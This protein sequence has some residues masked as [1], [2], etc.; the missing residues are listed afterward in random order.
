MQGFKGVVVVATI[1]AAA[2]TLG[3][4]RKEVAHDSFKLGA[5]DVSVAVV[6]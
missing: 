5:S 1:F 6:R 4:C 3:A 2:I